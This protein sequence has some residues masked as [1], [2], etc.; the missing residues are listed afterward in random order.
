MA[1]AEKLPEITEPPTTAEV[2][3]AMLTENTGRHF[4]DSG[5]DLGRAWQ[6]NQGVKFSERPTS[7]LEVEV[8]GKN[9]WISFTREVFHFLNECVEYDHELN[10]SF[11]E[12]SNRPE[13][14]REG[15]M[16]VVEAWIDE[17]RKGGPVGQYLCRVSDDEAV[18]EVRNAD[19]F[20]ED[21]DGYVC[22]D[23]VDYY[24]EERRPPGSE[25][26]DIGG[27]YGEGESFWVNTYNHQNNL[28]QT[29]QFYFWTEEDPETLQGDTTYVALQIHGGADVRGGYTAPVIFE[30]P[31]EGVAILDYARG[32]IS[33]SECA[34]YWYTDDA[35]R[36]YE[37]GSARGTNL[38]AYPMVNA[39]TDEGDDDGNKGPREGVL[40][41]DEDGNAH[42]PCCGTGHLG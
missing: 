20:T 9:G 8:H 25:A 12:L 42:C 22:I 37:D 19:D 14:E 32:N 2:L 27:I 13:N 31:D 16:A 26:R 17:R 28:S 11:Q 38:E 24:V 18:R 7:K 4:L 29:L 10:E 34:A 1:A 15:W 35:Y 40:F 21:E 39:E 3:Q 6:R 33:C 5:G 41:V 23:G 30:V 36:W